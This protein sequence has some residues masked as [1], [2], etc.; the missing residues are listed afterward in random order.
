MIGYRPAASSA[1]LPHCI[2]IHSIWAKAKVSGLIYY[3]AAHI[4]TR[5]KNPQ[6]QNHQLQVE[7]SLYPKHHID[8]AQVVGTPM[9]LRRLRDLHK[10]VTRIYSIYLTLCQGRTHHYTQ[11]SKCCGLTRLVFSE[12]GWSCSVSI[13]SPERMSAPVRFG[14]Q[15][16]TVSLSAFFNT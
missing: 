2:A 16:E 15:R 1:T 5:Y 8:I 6:R 7:S 4:R 13:I 10:Q 9:S 3:M 14:R 11:N 12:N